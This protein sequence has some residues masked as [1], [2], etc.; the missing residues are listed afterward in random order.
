MYAIRSYYDTGAWGGTN[1]YTSNPLAELSDKGFSRVNRV[2]MLA[3][4]KIVQDLSFLTKGLYAEFAVAYD[5]MANHLDTRSKN[6]AYKMA[7]G[8][9]GNVSYQSFGKTTE[10]AFKTELNS[11]EMSSTVSAITGYK[12]ETGDHAFD[13][14][15]KYE[16][17]S[18]VQ[19]GRNNTTKRQSIMGIVSYNFNNK[20]VRNN[21]V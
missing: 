21:F 7:T 4:M 8:T 2:N 9:P 3:D 12:F 13:A 20:Y 15:I 14:K 19:D 10:L 6:Y 5:N 16:Q 18:Q 17:Q 1:L 11:L